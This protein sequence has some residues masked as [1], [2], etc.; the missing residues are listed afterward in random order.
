M[1]FQNMQQ[2]VTYSQDESYARGQEQESDYLGWIDLP[3]N[4]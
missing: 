3:K 1:K 4:Y 2:Q